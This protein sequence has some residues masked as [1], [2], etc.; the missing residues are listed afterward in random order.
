MYEK[1]S[2]EP[3]ERTRTKHFVSGNAGLQPTV[4]AVRPAPSFSFAR[5]WNCSRSV[6]NASAS[7]GSGSPCVALPFS[8][9]PRACAT[10]SARERNVVPPSVRTHRSV[11]RRIAVPSSESSTVVEPLSASAYTASERSGTS[12][13][14]R[15][16]VAITERWIHCSAVFAVSSFRNLSR[17]K[18]LSLK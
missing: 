5:S 14:I 4:T 15:L 16:N 9:S 17:P 3:S 8:I 13:F 11:C 12:A 10:T 2:V 1:S 6:T 18:L 7:A